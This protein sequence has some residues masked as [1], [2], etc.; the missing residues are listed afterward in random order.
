[1]NRTG[2]R[3]SRSDRHHAAQARNPIRPVPRLRRPV[4]ELSAA[5]AS[6]AGNS[7]VGVEHADVPRPGRHRDRV[8]DSRDSGRFAASARIDAPGNRR[9]SAG[10]A[11]LGRRRRTRCSLAKNPKMI[12]SPT[13]DAPISVENTCWAVNVATGGT[14]DADGHGIA[15]T[16]NR[17]RGPGLV[18]RDVADAIAGTVVPPAVDTA[19]RVDGA[20]VVA[21]RRHDGGTGLRRWFLWR[22]DRSRLGGNSAH[23][24]GRTR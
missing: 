16:A 24:Q 17:C 6:P 19:S 3:A 9:I 15:E 4:T 10:A 18:K 7:A 5:V 8:G 1:M 21:A 22:L 13:R 11:V 23:A 20:G 14:T 12:P 2:V